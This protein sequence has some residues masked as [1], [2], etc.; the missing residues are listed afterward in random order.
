M[1]AGAAAVAMGSSLV[2]NATVRAE[3]AVAAVRAARG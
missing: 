1:I 2:D 3:R